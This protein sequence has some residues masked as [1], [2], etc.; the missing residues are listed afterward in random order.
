MPQLA[1]H[2]GRPVIPVA[3]PPYRSLGTEEIAAANG[4][5]KTGCC[6]IRGRGGQR[7]HGGRRG[8][9][10]R[11]RG[12]G[13]FGVR[14][15]VAVNSWTSGLI[16]AV[17]AIGTEPGEEIIVTP[18]TMAA[19]ATAIVHWNAIPVFADIDPHSFNLDPAAVEAAITPR[20]RAIMAVD[21]FGQSADMD[22]LRAIAARH[23]L[24]LLSD[25]AQAPG[26]RYKGRYA[27]TMA[28]IG[29][30]SLNYH[31]HIHCGEGGLIVTGDDR[32]A[33][34]LR[35][36]RNHGEAV[37]KSDDPGELANIIGYNFRLGEVE[38]A[39]AREQLRKLADKV[40]SRQ[41]AAMRL[42]AG[43]AGL[44]GL[45]PPA[46][47][48]DCTHVYYLFA[49]RL[50][51]GLV[52]VDRTA[53][54]EALRA[55]GVSGLGAGYQNIHRLPM[56][57]Q[58]DRLCMR[59]FPWSGAN[60]A[61]QASAAAQSCPVAER[62]H[63]RELSTSMF[64]LT[65]IRR[66]RPTRWSP[67]FTKYGRTCRACVDDVT[68]LKLEFAAAAAGIVRP[69]VHMRRLSVGVVERPPVVRFSNQR[70]R[71]HTGE[72]ASTYLRSFA[73]SPNL[74]LAV[75]LAGTATGVL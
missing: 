52:D 49:M 40:A 75:R 9:C 62:L 41:S 3:F 1:V 24:K 63:D 22:R 6:R 7:L 29:G 36:I 44:R 35:L 8:A 28:D 32:Y 5:L 68:A 64:V 18:W 31:K 33:E 2:G 55:E 23:D 4:V 17:G 15:A 38:S 69:V 14:H 57:R 19:S 48:T 47:S 60:G 12:C 39:I 25:T 56:F 13:D 10:A 53:I 16:A 65:N 21:I 50:D 71:T 61:S 20:T 54:V 59:G 27:G 51:P 43:L 37:I 11:N 26:A 73:D 66:P 70:F 42:R 46:V 58:C 67:P 34:R 72:S 45:I 74:F 30:F